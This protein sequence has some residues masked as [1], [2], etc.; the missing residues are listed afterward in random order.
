MFGNALE[1]RSLEFGKAPER[2][3]VVEVML[4]LIN[5]LLPWLSLKC[6]SKPM[7]TSLS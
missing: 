3:N 7:S 6:L 1:P 5:L 2:L 4:S